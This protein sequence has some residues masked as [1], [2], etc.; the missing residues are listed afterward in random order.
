MGFSAPS[1]TTFSAEDQTSLPVGQKKRRN[2][3]I[4]PL[5]MPANGIE[6]PPTP[7]SAARRQRT[8]DLNHRPTATGNDGPRS[9]LHRGNQ[10]SRRS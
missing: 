4:L 10:Q 5:I 9:S 6:C 8:T 3:P 2:E 7:K 1:D